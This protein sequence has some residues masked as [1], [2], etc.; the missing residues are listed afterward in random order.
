MPPRLR[1]LPAL[2]L[3]ALLPLGSLAQSSTPEALD[4]PAAERILL[5]A[6]P[7]ILQAR[8]GQAAARAGIDIAGARPNPQL[9]L[10]ST[11]TDP[12]RP[13]SRGFWNSWTDNVVRIDQLVERGDKRDLRLAAADRNLSA[14]SA[15]LA[16]TIRLARIDLAN[17]VNVEAQRGIAAAAL[18]SS[19]SWPEVREVHQALERGELKLLYLAPE[20][21]MKAEVLDRLAR[22]PAARQRRAIRGKTWPGYWRRRAPGS[23]RVSPG[24]ESRRA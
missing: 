6:N 23:V 15:D 20:R 9:T 22:L 17:T 1:T 7:A 24:R 2:L 19:M 14:S 3:T 18:N 11:S 21:L 10:G 5:D 12:G 16:N 13:G 8:A 4:L